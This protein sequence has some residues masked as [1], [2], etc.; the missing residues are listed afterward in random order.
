MQEELPTGELAGQESEVAIDE[1]GIWTQMRNSI[2]LLTQVYFYVKE[3]EKSK[4]V[5]L[6]WENKGNDVA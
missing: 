6:T 1:K 5:T 3:E 4:E 2:G